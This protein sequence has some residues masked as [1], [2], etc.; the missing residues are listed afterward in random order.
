MFKW[1]AKMSLYLTNSKLV[2]SIKHI[3]VHPRVKCLPGQIKPGHAPAVKLID[4]GLSQRCDLGIEVRLRIFC[5]SFN[6][7]L[8][9]YK[10]C[11]GRRSSLPLKYSPLSQ[12]VLRL[13][14]GQSAL[15]RIFCFRAVHLFKVH[16]DQPFCIQST[17]YRQIKSY[18]T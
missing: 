10:Q 17:D 14:C 5:E 8:Y 18:M 15:S 6:M 4:F 2:W 7:S 16:I 3:F 12:L 9:R 13:I 1:W 11:M